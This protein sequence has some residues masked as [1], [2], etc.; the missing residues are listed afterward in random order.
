MFLVPN[1]HQ[2]DFASAVS[3][4]QVPK[5]IRIESDVHFFNSV[6]TVCLQ[7]DHAI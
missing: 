2:I 4:S 7:W 1:R 3:R 5:G 6:N